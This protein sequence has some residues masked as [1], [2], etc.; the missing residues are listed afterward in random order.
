[1]KYTIGKRKTINGTS[2]WE[3]INV[4]E[5]RITKPTVFCLGGNNT[6]SDKEANYMA[7]FVQ[8]LIGESEEVDYLS[9]RYSNMPGFKVGYLSTNE[10]KEIVAKL[11]IPLVLDDNF[12]TLPCEEACKNMRRLTI[13]AHCFGARE[14]VPALERHLVQDLF[15]LGYNEDEIMKIT[16]QVFVAS[17]VG[18]ETYYMSSFSIKSID[19]C[20]YDMDYTREL[21]FAR[22]NNVDINEQD[23]RI[24]ENFRE[25]IRLK[26][27]RE[28]ECHDFMQMYKYILLRENNQIDLLTARLSSNDDDHNITTLQRGLQWESHYTSTKSGDIASQTI[29]YVLASSVANSLVNKEHKVLLPIDMQALQRECED[30]LFDMRPQYVKDRLSAKKIQVQPT[31]QE[32][33]KKEE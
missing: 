9:L 17:F 3:N 16:S 4:D 18:G 1:M 10:E 26:Q 5:Y 20:F 12:Q 24:L 19:D 2:Q 21:M 30:L 11:F 33:R 8:R 32:E 25:R 7:K 6:V 15:F 31:I 14:A 27:N 13:M 23:K 22:L 28:K 29:A